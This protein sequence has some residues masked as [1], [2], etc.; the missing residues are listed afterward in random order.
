[1]APSRRAMTLHPVTDPDFNGHQPTRPLRSLAGTAR[2]HPVNRQAQPN[3]SRTFPGLIKRRPL[4]VAMVLNH[5][6]AQP[7]GTTRPPISLVL[8]K[9]R[10]LLVVMAPNHHVNQ[11]IA[12]RPT[13]RTAEATSNLLFDVSQYKTVN[14]RLV[15]L[16]P[17]RLL[18]LPVVMA[19][20]PL[21]DQPQ[22]NHPRPPFLEP[23]KRRPSP[24]GTELDHRATIRNQSNPTP[25]LT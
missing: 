8:I 2:S 5:L 22:M 13:Y 16:E 1:M 14:P 12:A 19:P 25:E 3:R 23:I 17:I 9:P 18:P 20:N 15:F 10:L 6:A 4:H 24:A 7:Q 21:A 11:T